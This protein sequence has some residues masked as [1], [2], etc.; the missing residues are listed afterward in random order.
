M[1]E[2]FEG[3]ARFFEQPT[4]EGLKELLKQNFGEQDYLDFKKQW[5]SLS[6]IA[7]HIIAFANSGGGCIVLGVEQTN[8]ELE[9]VGLDSILD[10]ADIAKGVFKYLPTEIE[11]TVLDFN[12]T[13]SE[14]EKIVGKKF[15]VIFIEYKPEYIP[16]VT[17]GQG[18][19]VKKDTIY[20]RRGTNTITATYEDI[21]RLVSKRIETGYSSTA[22]LD[23]EQHLAQLKILYGNINRNEYSGG[24]GSM[25]QGSLA[26]MF[27]GVATPNIAYPEEDY[28]NFILRMIL[29][30]KVRIEKELCLG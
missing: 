17:K 5:T 22:E 3:F 12:F 7:K 11:Y 16:F 29:K 14:Y 25:I 4:R 8:D 19:D 15:Q 9:A 27:K 23:L 21:Q 20:V 18:D 1:K 30:K 28:E 24:I 13:S 6:K 26:Q 2:E 10:K